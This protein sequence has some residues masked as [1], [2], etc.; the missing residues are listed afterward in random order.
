MAIKSVSA[1]PETRNEIFRMISWTSDRLK[2]L[3]STVELADVGEQELHDGRKIKLPD[4]LLGQLGN[5][6]DKTISRY[7]LK[8]HK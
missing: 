3:G 7:R 5:V 4:V 2:A 8:N 1:W 6:R